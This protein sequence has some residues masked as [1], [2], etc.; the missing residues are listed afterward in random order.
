MEIIGYS[1]IGWYLRRK[2]FVDIFLEN[3]GY[4]AG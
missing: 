1:G 3:S 4:S 2:S